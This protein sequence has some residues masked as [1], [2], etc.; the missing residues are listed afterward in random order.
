MLLSVGFGNYVNSDKI[1]AVVK[2]DTAPARRMVQQARETGTAIDA[3]CGKKTKAVVIT[4]NGQIVLSA[5]NTETLSLRMQ[6]EE[7]KYKDE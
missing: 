7:N 4:D 6:G 3:S 5:L 2:A 1:T